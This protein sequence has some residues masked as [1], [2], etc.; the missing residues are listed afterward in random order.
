MIRPLLP[1]GAAPED[2]LIV[3][4]GAPEG[5]GYRCA[6]IP[7]ELPTVA[8]T[9]VTTAIRLGAQASRLLPAWAGR[10]RSQAHRAVFK[11]V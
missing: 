5:A 11:R 10:P 8:S 3:Y 7:S 1:A 2:I 6:V 4:A 9:A